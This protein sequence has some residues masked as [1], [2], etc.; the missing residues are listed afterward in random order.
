MA[1]SVRDDK[2]DGP[3]GAVPIR[4]YSPA[5]EESEMPRMPTL[6]WLHGGGFFRGGLDLPEADS[7]A[8]SMAA[9]GIPVVSVAYRLAP[10]PLIGR[11]NGRT[12]RYPAPVDDTLAALGAVSASI[13][14][15]LVLGGASAGA[16]IAAGAALRHLDE[17][18]SLAGVILAYGFFHPRHPRVTERNG[19]SRGH[20]RL[21]HSRRALDAMNRNYVGRAAADRFAFPGGDTIDGFPPTLMIN[22]QHD[23]M[24]ASGD[25]FG[26]ELV[27]AGTRVEHH[28]LDGSSHA[29]LNRPTSTHFTTGIDLMTAW[30]G[31]PDRIIREQA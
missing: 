4:R 19:H 10:L 7:V 9:H 13:A 30:L 31:S 3:S 5:A 26:R 16:C 15:P 17:S 18:G 23:G 21:T 2:I 28:V 22:A 6:V 11:A 8:R 1:V 12:A 24:R 14:G 20:R 27:Q 25:L 29:F